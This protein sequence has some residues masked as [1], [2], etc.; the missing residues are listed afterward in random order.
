MPTFLESTIELGE[1]IR[2]E[3]Q[4]NVR[5]TSRQ[6]RHFTRDHNNQDVIASWWQTH[7]IPPLSPGLPIIAHPPRLSG[8]G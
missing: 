3:N 6:A 7:A 4:Q 1:N 8:E 2:V 5:E